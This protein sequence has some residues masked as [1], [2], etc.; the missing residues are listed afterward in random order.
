VE[1]IARA[2]NMLE[3]RARQLALARAN[4]HVVKLNVELADTVEKLRAAQ[5]D[6]FRKRKLARVEGFLRH[7]PSEPSES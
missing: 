1:L 4:E 2:R 6:V 5:H 3:L 7:R